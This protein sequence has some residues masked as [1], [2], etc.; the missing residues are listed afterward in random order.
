MTR[1]VL[2]PDQL[3]ARLRADKAKLP[4]VLKQALHASAQRGRSYIVSESPVDRGIL[5]NAWKVIE[6]IDGALLQ[7]DQPYAGIVERGARP[8]KISPEGRAALAAW[9]FRKILSGTLGVNQHKRADLKKEADRIAWAIAKRF[10]K[11]GMKGSEFVKKSLPVLA[12]MMDEEIVE[13]LSRFFD[14]HGD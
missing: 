14:R 2:T 1:I 13:Y 4:N 9:A 5:R 3:G 12:A 10:E 11:I 7:N 8:F 6:Q